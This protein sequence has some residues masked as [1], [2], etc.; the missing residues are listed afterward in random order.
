MIATAD[1]APPPPETQARET[2]VQ[3]VVAEGREEGEIADVLPSVVT[4]GRAWRRPQER[5][6]SDGTRTR[7]LRRDRT[8]G[9]S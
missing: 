3:G 7:D 5:D 1:P 9:R 8:G 6:G 2:R 4:V